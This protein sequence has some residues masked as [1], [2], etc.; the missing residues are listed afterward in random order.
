MAK[1]LLE[2]ADL[3][4]VRGSRLLY[5]EFKRFF[6]SFLCKIEKFSIPS[7]FFLMVRAPTSCLSEA[8]HTGTTLCA[9]TSN[10]SVSLQ[11]TLTF[12]R[13][14]LPYLILV[15]ERKHLGRAN[16]TYTK[17]TKV[18]NETRN[19]FF[20]HKCRDLLCTITTKKDKRNRK[21]FKSPLNIH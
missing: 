6:F 12:S 2:L 7:I 10:T 9:S 20:F 21:L 15:I 14:S 4:M 13:H 1:E 5:L 3:E 16:R 8:I 19:I 11:A 18:C 17:W